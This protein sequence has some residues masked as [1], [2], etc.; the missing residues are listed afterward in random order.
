MRSV[1]NPRDVIKDP[2]ELLGKFRKEELVKIKESAVPFDSTITLR[3]IVLK[4]RG[5]QEDA[6]FLKHKG[7]FL[8]LRRGNTLIEVKNESEGDKTSNSHYIGRRGLR[9]FFD[10]FPEY[11]DFAQKKRP[12][13]DGIGIKTAGD[14]S[15]V[16]N[17]IF[18]DIENFYT[19]KLG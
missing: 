8:N 13:F 2:I 6:L 11:I 1:F 3:D 12:N 14:H 7:L 19:N 15:L 4:I 17:M 18:K 16:F 5:P 9:K 10:L